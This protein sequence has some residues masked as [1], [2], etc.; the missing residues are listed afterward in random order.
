M[1]QHVQLGIN[2]CLA[3]PFCDRALEAVRVSL[4]RTQLA[5]E[6]EFQGDLQPQ[7]AVQQIL[8]CGYTLVQL[9]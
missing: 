1:A 8:H 6:R 9:D 3:I 2:A 5:I 4:R 7:R